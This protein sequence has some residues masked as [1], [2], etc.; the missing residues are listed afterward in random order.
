MSLTDSAIRSPSP[1]RHDESTTLELPTL[2]VPVISR[3][4]GI[5]VFMNYNDHEPPHVHAR[6]GGG[7]V[8]LEIRSKSVVGEFPARALRLLIEWADLHADE[9]EVNWER[10]RQ[11]KHLLP[12][13]PLH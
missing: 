11:H 4:Y 3:F 6:S 10:A 12:V 2:P 13:E 7:E 8:L 5:V 9:L 1:E